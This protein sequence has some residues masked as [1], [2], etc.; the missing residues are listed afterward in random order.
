MVSG[1]KSR[2]DWMSVGGGPAAGN[3]EEAVK[4]EGDKYY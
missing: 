2:V 4:S 1:V 3:M